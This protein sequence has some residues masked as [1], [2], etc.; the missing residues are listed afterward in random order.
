MNS[1]KGTKRAKLHMHR[2][3]L[4]HRFQFDNDL[5]PDEEV[6]TGAMVECYPV[7]ADKQALLDLIIQSSE[8]ISAIFASFARRFS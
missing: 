2:C 7:I 6:W 8:P 4:F 5:S 1:C 3:N